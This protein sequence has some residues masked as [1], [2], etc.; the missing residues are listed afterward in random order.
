MLGKIGTRPLIRN[1]DDDCR[2]V[3]EEVE[4]AAGAVD[5]RRYDPE[6]VRRLNS[7]GIRANSGSRSTTSGN[8]CRSA[9]RSSAAVSRTAPAAKIIAAILIDTFSWLDPG[10]PLREIHGALITLYF[11]AEKR[12]AQNLGDGA[13]GR[14][15]TWDRRPLGLPNM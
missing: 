14:C 8:C 15:C 9:L 11:F 13:S 7:S 4:I 2:S 5:Q 12:P 1:G 3:V 6:A 10:A